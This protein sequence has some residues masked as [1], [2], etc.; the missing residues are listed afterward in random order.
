MSSKPP[1]SPNEPRK[2]DGTQENQ[3]VASAEQKKGFALTPRTLKYIGAIA[4]G[5]LIAGPFGALAA[6]GAVWTLDRGDKPTNDQRN[7]QQKEKMQQEGE[8]PESPEHTTDRDKKAPNKKPVAPEPQQSTTPQVPPP[9]P[10][11]DEESKQPTPP[12]PDESV[13]D[14]LI[15]EERAAHLQELG[16]DSDAS[17]QDFMEA[18]STNMKAVEDSQE[19]S[20]EDKDAKMDA[21]ARSAK[22][23]TGQDLLKE[24]EKDIKLNAE[25]IAAMEKGF[26]ER[27]Q[28]PLTITPGG[29]NDDKNKQKQEKAQ[30]P[31]KKTDSSEPQEEKSEG[32][33]ASS[34]MVRAAAQMM[35]T[36]INR[37][38]ARRAKAKALKE[39]QQEQH[40]DI[41]KEKTKE[42][43]IEKQAATSQQSP[44][45]P[46]APPSPGPTLNSLD[47]QTQQNLQTLG[48][49]SDTDQLPSAKNLSADFRALA[50]LHHPDRGGDPA[51][52]NEINQ[53]YTA[54]KANDLFQQQSDLPREE[55][56]AGK[57]EQQEEED[58]RQ[59]ILSQD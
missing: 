46:P 29:S 51:V 26:N 25:T 50:K 33:S 20:D 1:E 18:V 52:F 11:I 4:A 14:V 10:P 56:T 2:P 38:K 5:F 19:S 16:L 36:L 47:L 48:Y 53:A 17:F 27:K 30:E 21:I 39:K 34:P 24:D 8:A 31:S 13:D 49:G 28:Q 6:G 9:P 7:K 40:K 58:L 22:A 43:S 35:E 44:T 15:D 3:S 55:T 54:L 57:I 59:T 23:L 42:P 41:Q 37:V 45:P 32:T 12:A